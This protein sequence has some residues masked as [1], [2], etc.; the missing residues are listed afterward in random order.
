[1][2]TPYHW[3][4]VG[5]CL[6]LFA[7]AMSIAH[8]VFEQVP[9]L[10]DEVAYLFQAQVFSIGRVYVDAP[11][12]PSCFFAPFVLD[13]QGRRFGKYP[14]GWPVLFAVGVRL[15]QL[16]WVNAAGAALTAALVFRL[17]CAIHDPLTGGL[18]A[19][20]SATSP[21]VLLLA[22]SMMSHTWCLVFVTA[23]LWCFC[24]AWTC[25]GRRDGWAL[26]TGLMLGAAFAIRPFTAV[27]VAVPAGLYAAWRLA[28]YHEWSQVWFT[29]VGFVALALSGPLVNAIW[30][31][32]PLTS[33]YTL[34]WPYDRLGFGAG[35]GPL[36][37]GNTIWLGLSG[38][39]AVIGHLANHLLG[40]PALSLAFVV[41]GFTFKPRRSWDL[42][43]AA[44]ALSLILGYV[45]YWT[46]GDVFGPRYSYEIASTLFVLSARGIVRVGVWLQSRGRAWI[47]HVLLGLLVMINLAGYLPWQLRRYSGLYGISGRTREIL[48]QADLHNALVIVQEERGWWDYAVAFSMN[49]PMLDGDVVYASDCSP[50]NEALIAEFSS[51][52]VYFFDG[53]IVQPYIPK[54]TTV[55]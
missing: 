46:S 7:A 8:L 9:H 54:G 13:H 2:W 52:D 14:P 53:E 10:E 1:M 23:F 29:V 49:T 12:D 36:P 37:G 42:F 11:T 3:L 35:T 6:V 45:L 48:D 27:T 32:D 50:Y 24:R 20:L 39:V 26:G 19:G 40:W 51:R 15:G 5:L 44:T 21:F 22:G 38:A 18:S 4:A 41:L 28:R 25:R 43:L 17:G 47:L 30:T 16:W 33:P 31:G 34:F 55:P